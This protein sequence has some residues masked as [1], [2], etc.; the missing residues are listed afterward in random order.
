MMG[1][2]LVAFRDKGGK[3][4]VLE[5][6]C[7]HRGTSLEFGVV[8]EK[9]IRCCYHGWQFDVDGTILDTCRE[10]HRKLDAEE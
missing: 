5:L 7:P 8:E 2:D 3:V 10:N 9:G 1:E 4:G 6:H